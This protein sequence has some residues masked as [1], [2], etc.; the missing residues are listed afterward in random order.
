MEMPEMTMR[1]EIAREYISLRIGTFGFLTSDDHNL[2][3]KAGGI[4]V[5]LKNGKITVSRE[6]GRGR[7]TQKMCEAW[8]LAAFKDE[9]DKSVFFDER[10]GNLGCW[11]ES[12]ATGLKTDCHLGNF[13]YMLE[14]WLVQYDVSIVCTQIDSGVLMSFKKTAFHSPI[15]FARFDTVR[16]FLLFWN[17]YFMFKKV[18]Y[19]GGEKMLQD[20]TTTFKA[21]R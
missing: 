2:S 14:R 8:T 11:S 20:V 12:I 15:V 18:G 5:Q 9:D 3:V 21:S 7:P 10:N 16:N 17:R 4:I 6:D 1:D 19:P 13:R